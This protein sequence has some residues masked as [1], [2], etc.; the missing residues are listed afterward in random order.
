MP[1]HNN[2]ILSL[3][4][5]NQEKREEIVLCIFRNSS[6]P[7]TDRQVME[8]FGSQDP[9]SVRP[10]ITNLINSG[11]IREVGNVICKVTN[12]QVRIC[13]CCDAK[14]EPKIKQ[15]IMNFNLDGSANKDEVL[16]IYNSI[17]NYLIEKFSKNNP[18]S[19]LKIK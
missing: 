18:K 6:V 5:S 4:E 7:L 8:K 1:I 3:D 2:S 11:Y 14:L 10:A 15:Y 9:N 12:R 17:R 16:K 19:N 13:T